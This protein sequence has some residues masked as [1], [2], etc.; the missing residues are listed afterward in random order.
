VA[1]GR[2]VATGGL[3]VLLV[4]MVMLLRMVMMVPVANASA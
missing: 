4:L 1:A 3:L 2:D